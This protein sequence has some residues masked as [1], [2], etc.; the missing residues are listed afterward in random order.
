MIT[1]KNDARLTM[2]S[3]CYV[4]PVKK[5]Y[6]IRGRRTGRKHDGLHEETTPTSEGWKA[7]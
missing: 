3:P 1:N 4:N 6:Q 7:L 2:I 5:E